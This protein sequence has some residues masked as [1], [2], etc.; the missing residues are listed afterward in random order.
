MFPNN[1]FFLFNHRIQQVEGFLEEKLLD[2]LQDPARV[3]M[4][5]KSSFQIFP[6]TGKVSACLGDKIFIS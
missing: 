1:I 2:I 5:D 3:L 4:G 6:K